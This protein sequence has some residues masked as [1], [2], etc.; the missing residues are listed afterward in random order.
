MRTGGCHRLTHGEVK[1][2][3]VQGKVRA[4]KWS[5]CAGGHRLL[6]YTSG[7][8]RCALMELQGVPPDNEIPDVIYVL[9]DR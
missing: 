8:H 3:L 9:I 7:C 5:F 1:V 2:G 6:A 4:R